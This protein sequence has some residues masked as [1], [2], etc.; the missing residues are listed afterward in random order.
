MCACVMAIKLDEIQERAGDQKPVYQLEWPNTHSPA[1]FSCTVLIA[2][3][4]IKP[5]YQL[6]WLNTHS[7]AAFSCTVL[8]AAKQIKAGSGSAILIQK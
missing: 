7:P 1:A 3:K 2:T 4:Q 8:I 6:E 5:V